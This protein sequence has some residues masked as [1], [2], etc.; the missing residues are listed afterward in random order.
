[1]DTIG[2]YLFRDQCHVRKMALLHVDVV[3]IVINWLYASNSFSL[4]V[5]T[6]MR[7]TMPLSFCKLDTI[8]SLTWL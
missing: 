7:L 4:S 5:L 6:A 2:V 8:L 1:M 3:A